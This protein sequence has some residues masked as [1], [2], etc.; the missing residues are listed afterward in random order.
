MVHCDVGLFENGRKFKLA[1]SHFVVAGLDGY[2]QFVALVLYLT[3]VTH[4]ALGDAAKV[5]VVHLLAFGG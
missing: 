2:A 3:H 5:V 1:W 4:D